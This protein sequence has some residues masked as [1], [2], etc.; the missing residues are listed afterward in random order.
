M[1]ETPA[2]YLRS[3]D[4]IVFYG[5]SIT[6][7]RYYTMFVE[8][9]VLTRFP[10][11]QMRF[12]NAGWG[13]DK[14]SGAPGR[15]IDVRLRR[16]VVAHLPT[17]VTVML[18]M[19]DAGWRAFD[20]QLFTDFSQGYEHIADVLQTS[21]PR[22][23]VTLLRP[24]PFDDVAQAPRF[25]GG[26]NEVLQRYGDFVANLAQRRGMAV[27][28][29]NAPVVEAVTRATEADEEQAKK[30]MGDR[31]HP[32]SA[33]HL[34]MAMAMLRAWNAPSFVTTV[35][36]DAVNLQAVRSVNSSVTQ[37]RRVAT[38]SAKSAA[39]AQAPGAQE[40][41]TLTWTQ[42]DKALPFPLNRADSTTALVLRSSDFDQVL[43]NQTLRVAGLRKSNYRLKINKYQIGVFS[44]DQLLN[45]INLAQFVTPM[46]T[47]AQ[48]VYD[49]TDQRNRVQYAAWRQIQ[50]PLANIESSK[51]R[52]VLRALGSMEN[53]LISK[54]RAAAQPKPCVY[55][56]TPVADTA[57]PA[58]IFPNEAG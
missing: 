38:T 6:E 9:Y 33:G 19:N 4:R 5:D 27:A 28:D 23:R 54:Q 46:T 15:P 20:P 2:F 18:G 35:D 37:V 40:D 36:I 56:L 30:I 10:S 52:D 12:F 26:Y 47:Q 44:A 21:L 58:P 48:R 43:N 39:N 53:E 29:L 16:D 50:L 14:V 55:E 51:Y 49:L 45:G 42:Q 17:V 25:P 7:H 57:L 11:W 22:A 24:S 1:Q 31:A 41:A 13:G 8:T 32:S 3:G 34:L